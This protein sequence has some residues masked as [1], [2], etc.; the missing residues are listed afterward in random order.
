MVMRRVTDLIVGDYVKLG[1]RWLYVTA[2][3]RTGR[4]RF[5][6]ITVTGYHELIY[7]CRDDYIQVEVL[8]R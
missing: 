1:E 8:G 4:N 5:I 2:V 7:L 3:Y 6:T